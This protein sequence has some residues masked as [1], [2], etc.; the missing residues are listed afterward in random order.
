[1]AGH[2]RDVAGRARSCAPLL[3]EI[4]LRKAERGRAGKITDPVFFSVS[5]RD[6]RMG[7]SYLRPH[8]LS[9][10][11][12]G[13]FFGGEVIVGHWEDEVDM[14]WE[15]RRARKIFRWLNEV[16]NEVM[17]SR[18]GFV[19]KGAELGN[20]IPF[21]LAREGREHAFFDTLMQRRHHA[22]GHRVRGFLLLHRCRTGV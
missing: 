6:L 2:A 10:S 3:L 21:W 22:G 4:I 12:L 13:I 8:F 16:V 17:S 19:K 11:L 7:T 18:H 1:M 20:G 5:L 9:R 14:G 15:M